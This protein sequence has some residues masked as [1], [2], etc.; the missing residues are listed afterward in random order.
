MIALW[1]INSPALRD[2]PKLMAMNPTTAVLVVLTSFALLF[3]IRSA[4]RSLL[5]SRGLAFLVI[6]ISILRLINLFASGFFSVD[7]WL[8]ADRLLLPDGSVSRMAGN[9]AVALILLNIAILLTPRPSQ[10]SAWIAHAFSFIAAI[11]GLLAILG[12]LTSVRYLYNLNTLFTMSA[13]TGIALICLSIGVLSFSPDRGI[14]SLRNHLLGRVYIGYIAGIL[15]TAIVIGLLADPFVSHVLRSF[16]VNRLQGRATVLQHLAEPYLHGEPKP[17]KWLHS[18]T[19]GT[20]IRM[21]VLRADGAL[22]DDSDVDP[23]KLADE[24][25]RPEYQQAL[26]TGIGVD[27]HISRFTSQNTLYCALPVYRDQT[28][29]GFV[30]TSISTS[31]ID[32]RQAE[33]R[34]II[35]LGTT[36]AVIVALIFGYFL[37]RRITN[38]VSA[39]TTSIKHLSTAESLVEIP[40]AGPVELQYLAAAFNQMSRRLS[41][42]FT[43]LAQSRR[44]AEAANR[45][46]SEFLAN[47]SHEIRTPMTAII[48]HSELLLDRDQSSSE[49]L[50]SAN[51]IRRNGEHLLSIIN[52]I[53]DFSKI[54]ADRM[55][56]QRVPCSPCVIMSQVT[57]LMRVRAVEKGI[58]LDIRSKGPMPEFIESDPQRLRQI[59]INLVGNAIKFTETGGVEVI[60][61]LETT[62]P[63]S[64]AAPRFVFEVSDS[65][66]GMST[67]QIQRLF[68]PFAQVDASAARRFGG[69]GLG[70][71]I[72]RR[73]VEM[74]GGEIRVHSELGKGSRFSVLINPGNLQAVRMLKDC[75]EAVPEDSS[76]TPQKKPSLR[77]T[78]RILLADDGIDNRELLSFY[79]RRAGADVTLAV[80]GKEASEIALASHLAG[81]PFDLILMDMQMPELDGFG[82]TARLR[83]KGYTGAIVALTAHAMESHR[84]ACLKAGCTDYLSKPIASAVLIAKAAEF[85]QPQPPLPS[86]TTPTTTSNPTEL[87]RSDL[88]DP[89]VRPLL[90]NFIKTLPTQ[91]AALRAHLEAERYKELKETVHQLKGAGGTFG[92]MPITEHAKRIQESLEQNASLDSI[93][94]QLEELLKILR[95]VEGY[96]IQN[97]SLPP[98]QSP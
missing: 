6:A 84:Q 76:E 16:T 90:D 42:R 81:T 93:A 11:A 70:L 49:R 25:N 83:S 68:E 94:S 63:T 4:P 85:M 30:R 54:E 29:I 52:D 23:A 80:N 98:K 78:G 3:L 71:A 55:E 96:D 10:R 92:L 14:A 19:E 56:V 40:V 47:M 48:G 44:A 72:C 28:L 59:L 39:M 67:T 13:H 46:K 51:N 24:V 91:A 34:G 9:T 95:S 88:I 17:D 33:M 12:H 69:T 73:L 26:A 18:L 82:A 60:A 32:E 7:Q 37:A 41:A 65:G 38:P 45:A 86:P 20:D 89:E 43:E 21:T 53:L 58:S 57:S 22:L 66:V 27:E 1:I 31:N 5:I 74:L 8:F 87:L 2:M 15:L 97:E 35:L 62:N 36:G 61:S 50:N 75:R 77:L 79:L 64:P